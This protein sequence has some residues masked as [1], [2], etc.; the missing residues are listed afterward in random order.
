MSNKRKEM[1]CLLVLG[2]AAI[3]CERGDKVEKEV[4]ELEQAQQESPKVAGDLN[5]QLEQAKA[6]VV[7]LE[8]K[9]ALAKQGVTDDVVKER[10]DVKEALKNREE[11]VTEQVKEAEATAQAHSAEAE[12][13][14]QQLE[15]T[16]PAQKVKAEV[17][18]E[19]HAL[20]ATQATQEVDVTKE[21]QVIPV[22][23]SHVVERTTAEPASTRESAK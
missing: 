17:K 10:N 7:R 3:G 16:P 14:R 4:K 8:E 12:R 2:L 1:A 23:R 13:A 5:Q 15:K 21:Q 6:E 18:T 9:L 20:P 11:H 19:T 22:E